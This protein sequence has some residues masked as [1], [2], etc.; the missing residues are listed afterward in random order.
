MVKIAIRDDD[1]N[2]FTEPG[3]IELAYRGMESLPISLAVIPFV[4]GNNGDCPE[5]ACA[6]VDG[7]HDISHNCALVQYVSDGVRNSHFEVLLHGIS[8]E[9]RYQSGRRI[10][11][12]QWRESDPALP[13]K[14]LFAR[15]HLAMTFQC[16]VKWFVPPSN[17]IEGAGVR[18]VV[19]AGMDL[20]GIIGW[21]LNR[22]IDVLSVRKYL[23][24]WFFRGRYRYPYPGV[25]RY[26]DHC[27]LNACGMHS[28]EYLVHLFNVCAKFSLP[29]VINT[30]YWDLRDNQRKR[31][32]LLRFVEYARSKGAVFVLMSDIVNDARYE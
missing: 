29:M 13:E 1:T 22:T 15:H 8:H 24:R 16:K 10:A 4:T 3:A 32:M 14:L 26:A 2:Y 23:S 28:L 7:P 21:K 12:M 30:H 27:E 9:Y 17:K 6:G 25:L 5:S 19:C 20:S 18:A 11:E 31:D